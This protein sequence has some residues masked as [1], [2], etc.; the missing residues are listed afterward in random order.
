MNVLIAGIVALAT[1]LAPPGPPSKTWP[2]GPP[3][4]DP[5]VVT[6]PALT[7]MQLC[8]REFKGNL[9][10]C[11][12]EN[13]GET[14]SD[15]EQRRACFDGARD[16]LKLCIAKP[17]VDIDAPAMVH[18]D[19]QNPDIVLIFSE[20]GMEVVL[21]EINN[22][23]IDFGGIEAEEILPGTYLAIID[24]PMHATVRVGHGDDIFDG[25]GVDLD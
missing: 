21:H 11:R 12:V 9:W 3:P 20:P 7:P 17:F 16:I 8:W 14:E 22:H 25:C 18:Q 24:G 19:E 10:D 4:Q 5:V 23:D 1:A 15:R 13:P 6:P 2:K